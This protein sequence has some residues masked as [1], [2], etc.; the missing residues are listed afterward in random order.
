MIFL[1]LGYNKQYRFVSFEIFF[2]IE[3][4]RVYMLIVGDLNR[5]LERKLLKSPCKNECK[6]IKSL[7]NSFYSFVIIRI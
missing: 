7:Y 5:N 2:F 6:S 4:C 1:Y 3:N